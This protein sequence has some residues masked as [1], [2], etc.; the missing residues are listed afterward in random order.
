MVLADLNDEYTF[1]LKAKYIENK[2]TDEIADAIGK[3]YKATESMLTRA[4]DAFR[5]K[6]NQTNHS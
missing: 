2:S 4:R 5:N 3:S 1:L 6:F